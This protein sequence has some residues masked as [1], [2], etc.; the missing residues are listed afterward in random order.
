VRPNR[1]DQAPL[2]Q[3]VVD[4][5]SRFIRTGDEKASLAQAKV[6]L[7]VTT[8]LGD[9]ATGLVNVAEYGDVP[10]GEIQVVCEGGCG[11]ICAGSQCWSWCE[12]VPDPAVIPAV[13]LFRSDDP[14]DADD[15]PQGSTI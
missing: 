5:H 3:S 1:A 10:G 13:M 2:S 11:L 6:L 9:E 12:P 15:M 8:G 4:F 7:E 14:A